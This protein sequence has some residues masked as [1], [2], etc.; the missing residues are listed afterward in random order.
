LELAPDAPNR[1]AEA[2][3]ELANGTAEPRRRL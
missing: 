1:F 3:V 2:L